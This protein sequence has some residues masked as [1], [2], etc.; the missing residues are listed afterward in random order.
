MGLLLSHLAGGA[1]AIRYA[2]DWTDAERDAFREILATNKVKRSTLMNASILLKADRLCGWTTP[3]LLRPMTCPRQK[4]SSARSVLSRKGLK[5]PCIA[6]PSPMPSG[7]K[8]PARK[9]PM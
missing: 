7:A 9:Q 1:L 2:L 6:N 5:L 8:S 3:T 4:A